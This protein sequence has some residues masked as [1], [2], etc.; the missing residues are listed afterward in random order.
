MRNQLPWVTPSLVTLSSGF[1][2]AGNPK[3]QDFVEGSRACP[4]GDNEGC[5]GTPE[6]DLNG[7]S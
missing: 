5:P 2:A 1:E 4:P 6:G 7:P 3:T